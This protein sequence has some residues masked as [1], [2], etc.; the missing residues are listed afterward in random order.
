MEKKECIRRSGK[1]FFFCGKEEKKTDGKKQGESGKMKF[2][3]KGE[4]SE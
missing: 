3:K 2:F 1:V 4:V